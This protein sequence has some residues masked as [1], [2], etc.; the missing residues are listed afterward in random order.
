MHAEDAEENVCLF[1]EGLEQTFE[2]CSLKCN[3]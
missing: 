1:L 3:L 2:K